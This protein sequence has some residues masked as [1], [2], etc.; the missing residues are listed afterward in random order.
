MDIKRTSQN[1]EHES[2]NPD[3]EAALVQPIDMGI[4]KS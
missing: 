1:Q 4:I 3:D 2:K